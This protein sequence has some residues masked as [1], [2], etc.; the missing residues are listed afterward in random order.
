MC[1]HSIYLQVVQ[2]RTTDESL[3]FCSSFRKPK[4]FFACSP[5]YLRKCRLYCN[6]VTQGHL[7]DQVFCKD[8]HE[9][10][11]F[12]DEFSELK[13]MT[14]FKKNTHLSLSLSLY[15][16]I[17]RCTLIFP[18][19]CLYLH[20]QKRF[21]SRSDPNGIQERMFRQFKNLCIR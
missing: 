18:K 2:Q 13:K 5:W 4:R 21:G 6:T 1:C 8:I 3:H 12:I 19:G 9:A 7:V 17:C 10:L 16:S 20:L 11:K 15:L 14:K